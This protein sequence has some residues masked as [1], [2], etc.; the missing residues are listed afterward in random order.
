MSTFS[1]I[2]HSTERAALSASVDLGKI[3]EV[4]R[5]VVRIADFI[6]RKEPA[7]VEVKASDVVVAPAAVTVQVPTQPIPQVTVPVTV[8]MPQVNVAY[9]ANEKLLGILIAFTGLNAMALIADLILRY[10]P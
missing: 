2:D 4:L 5:D 3:E 10:A 6:A 1:S 9:R 7:H 8:P